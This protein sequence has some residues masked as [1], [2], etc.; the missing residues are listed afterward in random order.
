ML[1]GQIDRV[2]REPELDAFEGEVCEIE[3]VG[4][5]GATVAVLANKRPGVIGL[6]AE[7]PD[8]KFRSGHG[9]LAL[10]G[11]GDL[12]EQPIGAGAVGLEFGYTFRA[13]GA[14]VDIVDGGNG[15]QPLTWR[16]RQG[17]KLD[18]LL[19]IGGVGVQPGQMGDVGAVEDDGFVVGDRKQLTGHGFIVPGRWDFQ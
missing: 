17:P 15:G 14:E 18:A 3:R 13:L 2:V 12:V 9:W 8:L 6:H 5:D 7:F 11:K 19:L 1:A 10:L 16:S 4:E